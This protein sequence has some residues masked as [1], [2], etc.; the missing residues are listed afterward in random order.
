MNKLRQLRNIVGKLVCF[1]YFGLSSL[2]ASFIIFPLIYVF[3]WEKKARYNAKIA[4]V[5]G[6]FSF[7]IWLMCWL[8]HYKIDTSAIQKYKDMRST[9]V[10]ANHPSLIDIVVL[11]SAVPHP[12]CIVAG[13]LFN[14]FWI[15]KIVGQLFVDSFAD[16]E[17]LLERCRKSLHDGNNMIIFPEGTRTRPETAGKPLKRGAA[18]IA[19]RAGADVLPI[20]IKTEN[21]VGLGKHES[22]LKVHVNG[23]AQLILEPHAM[24]AIDS[25]NHEPFA[26]AARTLTEAIRNTIFAEDGCEY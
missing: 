5:R 21:L 14:N 18:Q 26:Q 15:R 11:I 23:Y 10:V 8:A 4:V 22:L 9:V 20:H 2:F 6:H 12:D 13:R 16:A 19:L 24:L 3:I 7:F 25:F 1:V 17:V